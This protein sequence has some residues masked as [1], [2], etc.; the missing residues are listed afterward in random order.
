MSNK[1]ATEQALTAHM[2][3]LSP[4]YLRLVDESRL[5]RGHAEAKN[6]AHFR[7]QIVSDKFSNLSPLKRH[8]LVFN[9]IG[10]LTA[11]GV[12]AL[13]IRAMTVGEYQSQQESP[14]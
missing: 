12:H 2:Q 8:Q 1:S 9:T 7:M 6:G 11:A 4:V 14:T 5:H 10:D 3:A 13:S